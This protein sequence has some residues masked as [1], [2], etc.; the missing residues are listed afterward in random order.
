MDDQQIVERINELAHQ[1]HA[2]WEAE[3]KGEASDGDDTTAA[4]LDHVGHP[5]AAR[6]APRGWIPTT[7]AS[8]TPGR[9]RDISAD[10]NR[11]GRRAGGSALL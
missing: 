4:P 2:L 1:E 11:R 6:R 3:S 8:V 5:R 9:W 10:S 7:R